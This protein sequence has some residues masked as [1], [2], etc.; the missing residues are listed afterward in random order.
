LAFA[1]GATIKL[2][3]CASRIADSKYLA[4]RSRILFCQISSMAASVRRSLASSLVRGMGHD[5]RYLLTGQLFLAG[6]FG[7]RSPP[8]GSRHGKD[9]P[10][11]VGVDRRGFRATIFGW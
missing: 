3:A 6:I 2:W 9:P 10:G 7:P 11:T 1:S 5:G 4:F 8:V